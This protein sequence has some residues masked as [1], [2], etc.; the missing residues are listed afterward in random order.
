[1]C[2]TPSYYYYTCT[3]TSS[4]KLLSQYGVFTSIMSSRTPRQLCL[5]LPNPYTL[6]CCAVSTNDCA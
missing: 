2:A 4:R 3:H 6:P 5:L 1:M